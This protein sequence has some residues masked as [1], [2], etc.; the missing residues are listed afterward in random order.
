MKVT[1]RLGRAIKPFVNFPRWMNLGQLRDD[2][3]AILKSIQDLK[4]HRPPVR[5][6]TFDEAM[7]RLHLTE[8]DIQK[9]IK[10]CLLLS[11][12]YYSCALIF[13]IYT[14]YMVVHGHLGLIIGFLITAL[15]LVFA[16]RE[17]FWYFQLKTRTLGNTFHNWLSYIF[18]GGRK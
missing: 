14:I 5:K 8:D 2:G 1:K 13:L 3:R 9:R 11:I 10:N 7:T 4:V 12:L 18:R 17:H 6:E 15:M 16:Y